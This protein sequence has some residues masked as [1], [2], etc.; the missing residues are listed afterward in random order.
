LERGESA[1]KLLKRGEE[2][3][4]GMRMADVMGC[5]YRRAWR[6]R[7]ASKWHLMTENDRIN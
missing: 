3:F 7:M 1:S 5:L 4:D 6:M 2:S